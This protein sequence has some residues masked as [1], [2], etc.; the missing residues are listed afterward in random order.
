MLPQEIFQKEHSETLFPAF[1]GTKYQFL[2]QGWNSL[3]LS[4]KSKIFHE[5][6]QM[7]G[8]GGGE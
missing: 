2:R 8:D 1:Q 5:N 4:L 3:K 6:G 7:V